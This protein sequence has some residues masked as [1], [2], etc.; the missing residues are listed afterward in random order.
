MRSSWDFLE[1]GIK[2]QLL[3]DNTNKNLNDETTTLLV[4]QFRSHITSNTIMLFASAPS[5]PHGVVDPIPQLSQLAM[6]Y[7]IGLHVDACL[8][9][10]VLPFLDDKDKLTLPLFDFRLPGV[11]SISV[12]THKYGCATKGTSVVLY[13]SR[14]LQHASYFSYSS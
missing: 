11:T 8:G 10:F 6:E 9:G 5:W 1:S 7:D 12:D 3:L 4:N 13:R 14:E 2:P